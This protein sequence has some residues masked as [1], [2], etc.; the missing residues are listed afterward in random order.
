MPGLFA[1]RDGERPIKEIAH[2]CENLR[3]RAGLLADVK[4]AKVV[5][6]A[7]QRFASAIGKRGERVAQKLAGR[8]GRSGHWRCGHGMVPS[9]RTIGVRTKESK[10]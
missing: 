1:L 8:I 6:S 3:G 7:A 5:W 4:R 2:V 9:C 10:L